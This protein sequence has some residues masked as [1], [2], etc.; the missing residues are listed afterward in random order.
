MLNREKII[1][2]GLGKLYQKH[3]KYI[4]D[5]FSIV[6]L[7]DNDPLKLKGGD[8]SYRYISIDRIAEESFE[9]VL[10]CTEAQ[11]IPLKVQLIQLGVCPGKIY[12]VDL[13][14]QAHWEDDYKK[15]LS[16]MKEYQK[17]HKTL[18]LSSFELRESDSCIQ[19]SDYRRNA[20]EID[21]HYFYQ[22]ILVAS[23]I[24][25]QNP[26]HHVDV[27]SRVDGFVSHLLA[28]GIETTV[29]DIRPLTM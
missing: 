16:D 2:V 11:Y 24:I 8:D 29:T 3:K 5:K 4:Q 12:G 21:G 19:L 13:L 6:A 25:K 28:A 27:G 15:Y 18:H 26:G 22:D 9:K 20:G 14:V 10:V 23:K 7:T 1:V 17:L